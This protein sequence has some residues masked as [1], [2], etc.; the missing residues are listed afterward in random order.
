M[1]T[2]TAKKEAMA[3]A[4]RAPGMILFEIQQG[5]VSRG[6]SIA[7]LSQYPNEEEASE[8]SAPIRSSRLQP[9]HE[10]QTPSTLPLP[11]LSQSPATPLSS[12]PQILFPPLTALEVVG[13]KVDGVVLIV[14]LR[15]SIKE[16]GG[17]KTGTDDLAGFAREREAV[18]QQAEAAKIEAE[19]GKKEAQRAEALR[20]RQVL[21]KDRM[22]EMRLASQRAKLAEAEIKIA[23]EK[24]NGVAKR[25]AALWS[26]RVG[27]MSEEE[28]AQ[29]KQL[30]QQLE[31]CEKKLE[32][33]QGEKKAAE[34]AA[35]AAV[36]REKKANKAK[37]DFERKVGEQKNKISAMYGQ[38]QFTR[39]V[40]R[41]KEAAARYNGSEMPEAAPAPEEDR[42]KEWGPIGEASVENVSKRLRDVIGPQESWAVSGVKAN[43]VL[44]GEACCDRI[45]ELCSKRGKDRKAAVTSG[46]VE[47][48][49]DVTRK[50]SKECGLEPQ[51]PLYYK[52]CTALAAIT[53]KAEAES[54]QLPAAS[55][56]HSLVPC[57]EYLMKP[58]MEVIQNITRNNQEN[59]YK[60][61]RAQGLLLRAAT[62]IEFLDEESNVV[63][64]D[65]PEPSP[66]KKK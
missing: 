6:A 52:A 64:P 36:A 60:L 19:R 32:K 25:H 4:K 51:L 18:Q 11:A 45:T 23:E 27:N 31:E 29:Q 13:T 14:Q 50:Y 28:A 61:L 3:Y 26:I 33:A 8:P 53:K 37:E 44:A 59:T 63:R 66:K 65:R 41:A 16:P 15:P 10:D 48:I 58:A 54:I 30:A 1:S 46:L 34:Q 56:L 55:C 57:M 17:I 24:R 43:D 49:S 40:L 22:N 9:D 5:F 20:Q 38:A 35:S 62:L 47:A 21:W 7:W 12:L 42:G 2:T 39:G